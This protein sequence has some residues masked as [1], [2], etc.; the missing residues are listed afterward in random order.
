M[1]ALYTSRRERPRNGGNKLIPD[2]NFPPGG[3]EYD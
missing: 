2:T 3:G 1:R